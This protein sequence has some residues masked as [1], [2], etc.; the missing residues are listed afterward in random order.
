[1]FIIELKHWRG[2]ITGDRYRWQ[3]HNGRHSRP[4][5]NPWLL[6]NAKARE[7]RSVLIDR[8]RGPLFGTGRMFNLHLNPNSLIWRR[9]GAGTIRN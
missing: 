3:I 9:N 7:I 5:E 6:A 1:L 8:L 2:A 4:E